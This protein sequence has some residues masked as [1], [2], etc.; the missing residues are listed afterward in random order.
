MNPNAILANW[1]GKK[2]PLSRVRVSVLDRAFLFGDAVYEVIRVYGGCLFR[3]QEHLNRLNYSLESMKISGINL[4]TLSQRLLDTTRS[5]GVIDGLAY[6]QVSRGEGLRMH[7]Y[8]ADLTPNVLIYVTNLEDSYKDIRSVGAQAVTFND[9]RWRHND[10]KA[11]SLAANC[12]AA[13]YAFEHDCVDVIFINEHGFVTEGSHTSVFAV[14]DGQ[15]LV[16]PPS[17][18][19]LPGVTKA[20]VLELALSASIPIVE[21]NLRREAIWTSDE[22]FFAG[23]PE[24]ILPIVKVNEH[25]I[26]KGKPGVITTELYRQFM[27]LVTRSISAGSNLSGKCEQEV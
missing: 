22:L 2:M 24:E 20:I 11:T 14:R 15:L 18:N 26:G 5:S 4:S 10:I 16:T 27:E 3:L 23:T 21:T 9:I 17:V 12:M 7:R 6:L 8:P 25:A 13:Q 19:I 1:N